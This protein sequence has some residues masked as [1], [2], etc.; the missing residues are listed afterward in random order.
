MQI[1]KPQDSTSSEAAH[2]N[3]GSDEGRDDVRFGVEGVLKAGRKPRHNK[4]EQIGQNI[5][6]SLSIN[7]DFSKT[8][9]GF[10]PT[11]A[12]DSERVQPC[13]EEQRGSKQDY[14]KSAEKDRIKRG[15]NG[16]ETTVLA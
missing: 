7:E 14:Q 15:D 5:N 2:S 3:N 13:C 10:A 4:N 8:C 1:P 16:L 9:F 11:G 6:E 12:I